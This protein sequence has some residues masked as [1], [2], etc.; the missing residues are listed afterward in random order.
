MFTCLL[1]IFA[2]YSL[3]SKRFCQF[4]KKKVRVSF[5]L[6]CFSLVF[7]PPSWL[8]LVCIPLH[9]I[10]GFFW[11]CS[12][13]FP[14]RVLCL[15]S[16]TTIMQRFRIICTRESFCCEK[17]DLWRVLQNLDTAELM[18]LSF[19]FKYEWWWL[20]YIANAS[21]NCSCECARLPNI[22]EY[23]IWK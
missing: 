13:L 6:V 4:L 10:L 1:F 23:W 18:H 16:Y 8:F 17:A 11:D 2:F 14:W 22:C 5:F 3:I 19:Y 7:F 20:D 9:L 12:F 15:S 21:F